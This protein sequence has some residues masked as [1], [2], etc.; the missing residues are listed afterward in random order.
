MSAAWDCWVFGAFHRVLTC[1][2][3]YS[4]G[5]LE[6]VALTQVFA[7]GGILSSSVLFLLQTATIVVVDMALN[8]YF[9]YCPHSQL[10]EK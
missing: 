3:R 6:A 8:S 7:E 4:Q 10:D 9:G 5:V 1:C 2:R